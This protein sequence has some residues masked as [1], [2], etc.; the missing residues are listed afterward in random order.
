MM[1]MMITLYFHRVHN[2]SQD[3][4]FPYGLYIICYSMTNASIDDNYLK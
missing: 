1:M 3:C 4:N 2:Y